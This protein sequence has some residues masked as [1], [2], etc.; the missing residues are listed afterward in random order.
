MIA[1]VKAQEDLAWKDREQSNNTVQLSD[2]DIKK[3]AS[4]FASSAASIIAREM[5]GMGIYAK[6]REFARLVREVDRGEL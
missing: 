1:A 6:T 4:A 2:A 5:D 3:L